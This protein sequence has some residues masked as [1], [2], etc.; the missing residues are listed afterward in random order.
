MAV[1]N[2]HPYARAYQR[3]QTETATPTRLIVMLYDGALR[4][5]STAREKM[6]SQEIEERHVALIKAQH[7]LQELMRSLDMERG[8]EIAQNLGRLYDYMMR[9]LV[10]A[11]IH[12]RVEPIDDVMELLRELRESWIAVDREMQKQNGRRA[13]L[14]G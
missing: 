8:G 9:Q 14:D 5:L 12:D 13:D 10:E 3:T 7:I 11:N 4:F 6:A 2:A 1:A